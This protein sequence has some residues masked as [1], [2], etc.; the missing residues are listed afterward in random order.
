M[1]T[2]DLR[3]EKKPVALISLPQQIILNGSSSA[4]THTLEK[5]NG[6]VKQ[7]EVKIN[8]TTGNITFTLSATSELGGVLYTKAAIPE[9]ATT[10]Y[11]STSDATDFDAFLLAGDIIWTFTPSADPGVSTGIIDVNLYME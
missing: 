10:V 7:I 6:T 1:A 9:N 8:D 11:S 2:S 5:M 3:S 4:V